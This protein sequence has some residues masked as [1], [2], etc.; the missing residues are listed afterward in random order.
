MKRVKISS[1]EGFAWVPLKQ[2]GCADIEEVLRGILSRKEVLDAIF[3]ASNRKS[4]DG[5]GGLGW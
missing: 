3:T 2:Y 1:A 4:P 5:V